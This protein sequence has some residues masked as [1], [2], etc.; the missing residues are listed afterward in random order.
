MKVSDIRVTAQGQ[1]FQLSPARDWSPEC[2]P[3]RPPGAGVAYRLAVEP[4]EEYL[5]LAPRLR[6]IQLSVPSQKVIKR[7]ARKIMGSNYS[8][9][10]AEK[11]DRSS[12]W[13]FVRARIPAEVQAAFLAAVA[14]NAVIPEGYPMYDM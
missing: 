8:E 1:S 4:T 13:F 5:F 14:L 10:S 12:V 7:L 9:E 2:R 6:D 3:K 11:E